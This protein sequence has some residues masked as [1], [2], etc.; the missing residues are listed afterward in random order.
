[1]QNRKISDATI[2]TTGI[3]AWLL[4]AFASIKLAVIYAPNP[5]LAYLLAY[6]IS[7]FIFLVYFI[8]YFKEKFRFGHF[9]LL[10]FAYNIGINVLHVLYNALFLLES[11]TWE[12]A[13][14]YASAVINIPLLAVTWLLL[15]LFIRRKT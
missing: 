12:Y 3:I 8:G 7:A 2:L 4:L 14:M 1:M 9:L 13:R 11:P 15:Y 10:A 6:N 5:S